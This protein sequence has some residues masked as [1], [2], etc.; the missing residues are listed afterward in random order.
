M[1]SAIPRNSAE[2]PERDRE[3]LEFSDGLGEAK[4]VKEI[5]LKKGVPSWVSVA[6][7]KKV[8]QKYE[9]EITSKEG[10]N[11]VQFPDGILSESTPLWEDFV[12]GKFLDI[13]PHIAKVHITTRIHFILQCTY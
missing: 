5:D 2:P 13:N 8:L 4:I 10:K 9:V 12:V 1:D 11:K 7:D 3:V 6:K